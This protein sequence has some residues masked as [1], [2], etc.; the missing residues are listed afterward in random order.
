MH[1]N[2]IRC[3]VPLV[4]SEEEARKGLAI[5]EASL[6]QALSEPR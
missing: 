5:L 4:V 6:E 1:A 3:L 2:V